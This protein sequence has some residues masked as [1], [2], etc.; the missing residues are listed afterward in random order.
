MMKRFRS[1]LR[2]MLALLATT[3]TLSACSWYP[4]YLDGKANALQQEI[5]TKR[6]TLASDAA[7]Y[8]LAAGK[9]FEIDVSG[10]P[11]KD[12]VDTYNNL[13]LGS[14]TMTM[15]GTGA[16]GDFFEAWTDCFWPFHGRIGIGLGPWDGRHDFGAILLVS[17]LGY[18]GWPA[19]VGPQLSFDGTVGG[20]YLI[21]AGNL[22]FCGASASIPA[23]FL[24]VAGGS[25]SA[26]AGASVSPQ[27]NVG[28]GYS[29]GL[30][31]PL[32]FI[33]GGSVAGYGFAAPVAIKPQLFSGTLKN[34]IGINGAVSIVKIQKAR[35]Y[36]IGVNFD[37]AAFLDF[38]MM[39]AG[40]IVINWT[41]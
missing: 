22:E 37:T 38:G 36:Q 13:S 23:G 9:D 31:D 14:R 5:D 39:A 1:T 18:Q 7:A 21:I 16:S 2:D 4:P 30:I 26:R 12:I 25:P 10:Q 34:I 27:P 6:A 19:G 32:I 11:L 40:S 24:A 41:Q 20:I 35:A 28:I 29:L 8:R 17:K 15:D 3:A 33:A